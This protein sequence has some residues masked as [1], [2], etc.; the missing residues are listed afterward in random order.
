[1]QQRMLSHMSPDP[2]IPNARRDLA[3]VRLTDPALLQLYPPTPALPWWN[4]V[5]AVSAQFRASIHEGVIDMFYA[6]CSI[7]VAYFTILPEFR[8]ET[9]H[10]KLAELGRLTPDR[11]CP[12][13]PPALD[14][15]R[16]FHRLLRYLIYYYRHVDHSF[17]DPRLRPHINVQSDDEG[18]WTDAHGDSSEPSGAGPF[19][20]NFERIRSLH[21]P[22]VPPP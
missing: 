1:M 9:L 21:S 7:D 22:L 19:I 15:S 3:A 6:I 18:E 2:V 11:F 8:N 5:S 20:C 17:I 12:L 16:L 13:A 14:V 4:S 10:L